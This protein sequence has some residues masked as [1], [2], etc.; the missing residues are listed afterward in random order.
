[1]AG[2]CCWYRLLCWLV[3]RGYVVGRR[4]CWWLAAGFF[5]WLNC[6]CRFFCVVTAAVCVIAC[7]CLLVAGV[8]FTPK[9]N[10]SFKSS[11]CG[12]VQSCAMWHCD[13]SAVNSTCESWTA[14]PLSGP[15]FCWSKRVNAFIH[16]LFAVLLPLA[17]F[18]F[19]YRH[20][21]TYWLCLLLI[22]TYMPDIRGITLNI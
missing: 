22:A 9:T 8:F 14:P 6:R 21:F 16:R 4:R 7:I 12:S 13:S 18:D 11:S 1:M 19:A 2:I 3:A 15:T 10:S 20:S 5:G 17:D